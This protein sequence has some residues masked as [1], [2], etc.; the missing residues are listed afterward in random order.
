[1]SEEDLLTYE[2]DELYHQV[3]TRRAEDLAADHPRIKPRR[4]KWY[5]P[6][7]MG[8]T[9]DNI[10]AFSGALAGVTAGVVVC[11]LDVAKTRLQ[12]Q[13]GF[14]ALLKSQNPTV[15]HIATK[16]SGL[17]G[18]VTKI[19]KDEGVRG[20]YRGL[21][22]IV[23]GYL[24]TWTV[25]FLLYE[26]SKTVISRYLSEDTRYVGHILSALCAGGASTLVTNPIWVVKTRLMSQNASSSWHYRGTIDAF[27]SM[28][29]QEGL[30]VFYS[31]LGPA[32]LGLSHVAVQFPIY[33]RLKLSLITN[34]GP[35]WQ[36]NLCILLASGLSKVCAST[37]TY[38]HEVIRTRNQI[39][40]TNKGQLKYRGVITT[41]KII[42]RE[43]GW[44]AF[45][46]GLGTNMIRA[47]PSSAVTLFTYETVSRHLRHYRDGL[48]YDY[49]R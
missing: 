2:N 16:Y 28:Y 21:V 18:T 34:R 41:A 6:A 17:I 1:M 42:L 39:Q 4:E 45:Y 25:Y 8:L 26:K 40:P 43:E 35:E 20:L 15:R 37:I 47:V 30:R 24:P 3:H 48:I 31:G 5:H 22:P 38:P 32:L 49:G 27:R 11:P 7:V 46:A 9:D 44:R 33:E 36:N 13:G 14:T 23:I 10:N 29:R 12:A 19:L